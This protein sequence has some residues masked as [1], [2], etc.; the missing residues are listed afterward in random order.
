MLMKCEL[1]SGWCWAHNLLEYECRYSMMDDEEFAILIIT[2]L[3]PAFDVFVT[4]FLA[5]QNDI[6]SLH[7]L[8]SRLL[9]EATRREA[10]M[11]DSNT[12]I[13]APS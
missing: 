4:S 7:S 1:L 9:D 12:D 8:K 11:K 3:P 10:I 6:V 5:S 13:Y 2:S